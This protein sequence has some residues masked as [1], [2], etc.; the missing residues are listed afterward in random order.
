MDNIVLTDPNKLSESSD[1]DDEDEE[2]W[3]DE[4]ADCAA[5]SAREQLVP[6]QNSG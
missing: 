2:D 3:D 6:Q 4:E 5:S 1:A